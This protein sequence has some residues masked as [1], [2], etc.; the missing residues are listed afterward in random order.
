VSVANNLKS[1]SLIIEGLK[2]RRFE[3]KRRS[4]KIE[5]LKVRRLEGLSRRG[6]V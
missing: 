1:D 3:R 6:E 5:G 2:V 4:L